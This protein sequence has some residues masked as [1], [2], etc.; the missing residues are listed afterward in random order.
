MGTDPR[1]SA[2]DSDCRFRGLDNLYVVDGSVMPTSAAVNPSLTIAALSLRAARRLV[3]RARSAS[4][5]RHRA[6]IKH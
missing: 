2:L 6:V 1:T 5:I 3:S 4:E